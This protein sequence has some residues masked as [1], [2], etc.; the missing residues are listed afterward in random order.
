MNDSMPSTCSKSSGEI[1]LPMG[2]SMKASVKTPV[3]QHCGLRHYDLFS[4][5]N[6]SPEPTPNADYAMRMATG[7][8]K[9]DGT[10]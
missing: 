9:N 5:G 1:L 4:N 2:S 8:M 6:G 10:T 7:L 3:N